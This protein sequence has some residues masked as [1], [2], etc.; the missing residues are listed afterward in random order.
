MTEPDTAP[1]GLAPVPLP[2]VGDLR[3]LLP[4]SQGA[5]DALADPPPGDRDGIAS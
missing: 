3:E 5:P 1:G 2:P 4:W